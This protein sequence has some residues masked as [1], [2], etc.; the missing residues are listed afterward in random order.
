MIRQSSG[1]FYDAGN[2]GVSGDTTQKMID[3]I[4]SIPNSSE[5]VLVMETAND[6]SQGVTALTHATNMKF[7]L[8]E[9]M[10]KGFLPILVLGSP[11]YAA[12][13]LVNQYNIYDYMTAMKLGIPCFDPWTDVAD[14]STGGW[15]SGLSPDGIHPSAATEKAVGIKLWDQISSNKFSVLLNRFNQFGLVSN[16][17]FS[18]SSAGI[19]TGWTVTT[20]GGTPT[21]SSDPTFSNG[22]TFKLAGSTDFS[23]MQSPPIPVVAGK[24]YMLTGVYFATGNTTDARFSFFGDI[25]PD[26]TR[27][28]VIDYCLVDVDRY[29]FKVIFEPV[30]TGN[31]YLKSTV[32]RIN[33]G[34]TINADLKLARVQVY[35]MTDYTI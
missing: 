15:K 11:R 26:T 3:R 2:Y 34:V 17:C 18:N 4:D 27:Y 5:I 25:F 19:P 16:G 33:P 9:L 30:S 7:I 35:N 13:E 6:A 1:R 23:F 32:Y 28:N 20:V 24:T 10:R 22:N 14:T 29:E 21:V 8:E 12:Q 31:L